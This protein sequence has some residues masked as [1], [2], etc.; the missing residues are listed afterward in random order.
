MGYELVSACRGALTRQARFGLWCGSRGT[1]M[2]KRGDIQIRDPFVVPVR[3]QGMYYMYGT[4][5]ANCWA[6]AATGFNAFRSKD[7]EHWE[8]PIPVFRPPGGFWADRN[9]WAPEVHCYAGRWFMFAS[10]KAERV[11]R[12]TQVLVAD[13][14]EG[15]FA[16]WSD[17]PV[18][19]REWECLDGTLFVDEAGKPWMVFCHEWVQV[20]DGEMCAVRLSDDLRRAEGEP[21]LLF[22]ASEAAWVKPI[23]DGKSYVTDGPFLHRTGE[24]GLLML[25]ASLGAKGYAQGVARSEGGGVRGPWR[26]IAEPLF[27]NDGGHGMLFRTFDGRLML[28]LHSPNKTP[29]ERPL[30]MCVRE[31][32]G[33]LRVG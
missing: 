7:L 11:C 13:R 16:P 3:E 6:G 33:R 26:Q 30:F 8:G 31:E 2:F 14:P 32:E 19:P 10:F 25:W 29:N 21:A 15:P 18:T 24:G 20:K 5:D 4:T 9:F 23:R 27:A 1:G 22:R 28:T 12:G 17:G